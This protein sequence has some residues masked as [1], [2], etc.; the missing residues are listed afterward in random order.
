MNTVGA[1]VESAVI[2]GFIIWLQKYARSD[3]LISGPESPGKRPRAFQ[4]FSRHDFCLQNLANLVTFSER[5]VVEKQEIKQN[6]H[7]FFNYAF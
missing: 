4:I 5:N 1:L 7:F 6:T 2:K 3:W